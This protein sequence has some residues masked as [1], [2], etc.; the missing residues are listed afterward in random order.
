MK[1]R[2]KIVNESNEALSS[3]M[4]SLSVNSVS[5]DKFIDI[6]NNPM[7]RHQNLDYS[8]NQS[9]SLKQILS[10]SC[11]DGVSRPRMIRLRWQWT[12]KMVKHLVD[13][14]VVFKIDSFE[15]ET[16]IRHTYNPIKKDWIQEKCTVKMEPKRFEQGA[17]RACFRL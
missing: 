8:C 5:S 16:A 2:K 9:P 13:P 14:W 10:F 1:R 17:I 7:K 11:P 4:K 3:E 6:Y 12:A 15:A